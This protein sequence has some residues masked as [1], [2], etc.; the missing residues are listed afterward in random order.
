MNGAKAVEITMFETKL[1]TVK[2]MGGSPSDR[3]WSLK[4]YWNKIK[5]LVL[6]LLSKRP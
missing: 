1:I 4:K 3:D 5:I 6:G 2:R